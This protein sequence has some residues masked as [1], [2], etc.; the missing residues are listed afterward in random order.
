[1]K[2][3]ML[4]TGEGQKLPF[5]F[6]ETVTHV[7]VAMLMAEMLKRFHNAEEVFLA[8]AGFVSLGTDVNVH[9]ASESLDGAASNP[10]DAARIMCGDSVSFMPDA[11]LE[12]MLSKLKE[13]KG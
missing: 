11:M 8:S 4:E 2:Y 1:V 5:I 12:A 10:A 9:G 3:V 13:L 7:Y 6:P